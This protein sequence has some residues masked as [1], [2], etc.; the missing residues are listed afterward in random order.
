MRTFLAESIGTFALV[1]CG[2]GAVII[3]ETAGGALG[4]TGIAIVFGL[5]VFAMIETFGEVSGAH[6]NPA[7]SL[8]FAVAGR[9]PWKALPTYWLAQL[10]G[11]LLASFTLSLMFPTSLHLGATLPVG[12]DLRSFVLEFILTFLL[13]GVIMSVSEGSRETGLNAG[14][15]IGSII[16]LEALFAGPISGASMNPFRSLAP[17]LVSGDLGH[18]WIYLLAPTAGAMAASAIWGKVFSRT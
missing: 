18:L 2:T 14:A 7:V 11:A 15:A 10:I 6:L 17:A 5:I 13:M 1:F 8:G 9:F 4:T 16:G 12:G 3:N